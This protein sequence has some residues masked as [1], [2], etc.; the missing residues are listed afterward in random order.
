MQDVKK[1]KAGLEIKEKHGQTFVPAALAI[2]VDTLQS[3][4]ALVGLLCLHR[5]AF[6]PRHYLLP[7]AD[8]AVMPVSMRSCHLLQRATRVM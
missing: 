6:T 2:R 4:L 5:C 3:A 7:H 8:S 1:R